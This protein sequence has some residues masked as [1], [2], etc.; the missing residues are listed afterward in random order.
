MMTQ[1]GVD[2]GHAAGQK[3]EHEAYFLYPGCYHK[4]REIVF[5]NWSQCDP[6]NSRKIWRPLTNRGKCSRDALD[7]GAWYKATIQVSLFELDPPP[8]I[9]RGIPLTHHPT[10]LFSS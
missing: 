2:F 10:L 5:V 8:Y 7:P 6:G 1:K 9:K 4:G 3:Q